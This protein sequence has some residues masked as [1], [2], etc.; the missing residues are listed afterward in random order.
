MDFSYEGIGQVV[1]TF[2]RE[3]GVEPG[4]AVALTGDCTVGM[5]NSGADLCGKVL[6][7]NGDCCAVQV[8]GFVKLP[9]TGESPVAGYNTIAGNG[10]GGVLV[11]VG[12][13]M[14]LIVQVDD[15][16]GTIVFKI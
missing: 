10:E 4:M 15:D 2:A 1:A 9:F 14:H 3:E 6:A 16:E 11:G 5:A 7:V 12:S 8:G 13:Q